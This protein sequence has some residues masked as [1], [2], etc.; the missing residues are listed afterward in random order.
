LAGA[1]QGALA[2]PSFGRKGDKL[3]L[4]FRRPLR[5]SGGPAILLLTTGLT[6]RGREFRILTTSLTDRDREFRNLTTNLTNSTN[7]YFESKK[8]TGQEEN[9][10]RTLPVFVRVVREVRGLY[11]IL[12]LFSGKS[13]IAVGGRRGLVFIDVPGYTENA[14]RCAGI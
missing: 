10:G 6:D 7:Y 13:K 14:G 1:P 4:F 2:V 3:E 12:S 11:C 8:K 9:R 5:L